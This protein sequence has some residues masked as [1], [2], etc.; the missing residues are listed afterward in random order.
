MCTAQVHPPR[1]VSPKGAISG[2]VGP[3]VS[4][5]AERTVQQRHVPTLAPSISLAAEAQPEGC[6]PLVMLTYLGRVGE[7]AAGAAGVQ[8]QPDL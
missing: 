2:S 4:G 8:D 3:G 5:A 7:A 6:T 1:A